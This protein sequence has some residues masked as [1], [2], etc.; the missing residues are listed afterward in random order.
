M[1]MALAACGNSTPTTNGKQPT[2]NGNPTGTQPTTQPTKPEDNTNVLTY[3]QFMATEDGTEVTVEFY[4]QGF[5]GWWNDQIC[6]YG[7]TIEGGYFAYNAACSQEDANKIQVGTKVRVTG[8]K[9]TYQGLVEI[10]YSTVEV[11]ENAETWIAET[12]DVTA[13]LGTEEMAQHMNKKVAFKGMTIVE[14]EYRN[15][16]PG[17]DIYVTASKDGVVYSF[18]VEVYL[19]G[20]STDVY[21]AFESLT[22]GDVVDIEAFLYY[23]ADAINP[24]ITAIAKI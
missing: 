4:V 5:Q 11:L 7:Q 8:E 20:T 1:V 18:C 3:E 23:Y 10:M 12:T 2:T 14:V 22:A 9:T 17:D 19:T 13:L 24:H 6:L 16:E 21:K 15:G